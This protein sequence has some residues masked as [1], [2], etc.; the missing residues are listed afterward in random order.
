MALNS[1]CGRVSCEAGC[2]QEQWLRADLA[3]SNR[4]CTAAFWHHPLFS[5]GGHHGFD[6]RTAAFWQALQDDGAELVLT[7]HDHDYERFAPQTADGTA[8]DAGIRAFVVGTGGRS[9]HDFAEPP[10]A[11]SEVRLGAF[12]YLRLS[13]GH[14]GY[15][16]EFVGEDATVLDSGSGTCSVSR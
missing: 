8:S 16:F 4:P 10:A 15:D 2:A 1:N 13:L 9:L 3:A 14:G 7:G 11:N 6:P 12:G 5:S